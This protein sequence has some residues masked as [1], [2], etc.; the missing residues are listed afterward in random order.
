MDNLNSRCN[1][2]T[3]EYK[4]KYDKLLSL[5]NGYEIAN[6]SQNESMKSLAD[7]ISNTK[8]LISE[9]DFNALKKPKKCSTL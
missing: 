2:V 8:E 9:S 4:K 6:N 3:E 1:S 5:V 7:I